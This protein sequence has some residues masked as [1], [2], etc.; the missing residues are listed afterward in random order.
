MDSNERSER[1]LQ[2]Y[3]PGDSIATRDLRAQITQANFREKL[4]RKVFERPVLF[5]GETGTGKEFAAQALCAHWV[6]LG[7]EASTQ[8]ELLRDPGKLPLFN[9]GVL[10]EQFYAVSAA[11][12]HGDVG[13]TEL[14]GCLR[15]S[16]TGATRDRV[17][18]LG[19][20]RSHIL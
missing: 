7:E 4:N 2:L 14:V 16:Y 10:E 3:Y 1:F 12:L 20:N 13:L 19:S 8:D 5:E 11:D 18:I 15:G 17:G 9:T 6:W